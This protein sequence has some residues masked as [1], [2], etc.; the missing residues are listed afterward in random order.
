MPRSIV[1]INASFPMFP[2]N[3]VSKIVA[4]NLSRSF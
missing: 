3:L 1:F 4:M 2:I